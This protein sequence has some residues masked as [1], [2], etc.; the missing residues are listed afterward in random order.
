LQYTNFNMD[1]AKANAKRVHPDIGIM[2]VSC[3]AGQGIESWGS[4]LVE[5]YQAKLGKLRSA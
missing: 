1:V 5:R 3:T 4:W 2:D